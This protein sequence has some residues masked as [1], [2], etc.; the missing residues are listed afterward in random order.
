M[1]E[2]Y[3]KDDYAF[4]FMRELAVRPTSYINVQQFASTHQVSLGVIKQSVIALKQCGLIVSKEGSRGGYRLAKPAEEITFYD[5]ITGLRGPVRLNHC[6][7]QSYHC[8][9]KPEQCEMHHRW[10]DIN[11]QFSALLHRTRLSD[12]VTTEGSA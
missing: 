7:G 11:D 2:L 6:T 5:I 10:D 8:Q 4:L 3:K 1:I 9:E 12:L